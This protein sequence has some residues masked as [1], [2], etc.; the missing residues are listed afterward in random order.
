MTSMAYCPPLPEDHPRL[1]LLD[2]EKVEESDFI[3]F[4][5]ACWR[6][7][8]G[9]WEIK[10]GKF[11]LKGIRGIYRMIGD[12]P[13]LADWYSGVLRIPKGK[14]L[15][16]IHMGFASVYEQELLIKIKNGIVVDKR[17]IN[18][19]GKNFDELQLTWDNLPGAENEFDGDDL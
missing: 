11:Y 16:Y 9:T 1:K 4:S 6:N 5:T 2:S 19:I 15:K 8:I 17:L 18:N 14:L 7:Y 12:E 3:V 10:D 13:I